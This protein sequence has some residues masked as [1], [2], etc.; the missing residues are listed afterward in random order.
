VG[1]IT[2]LL[3]FPLAPVRVTVWIA[4]QI[5]AQA[6]AEFYDEGTIR[7]RLM[8][9]EEARAAG[10]IGD[11]EAAAIEDELVARLIAGRG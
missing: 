3:T 1:L 4:E 5:L 7:A 9:V 2:G 10:E 11:E 8:E 6:E